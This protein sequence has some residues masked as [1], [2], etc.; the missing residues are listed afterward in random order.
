MPVGEAYD[1]N[2]RVG[3]ICI[4]NLEEEE[5]EVM[6]SSPMPQNNTV[7]FVLVVSTVRAEL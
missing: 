6:E 1:E 4:E 3:S 7:Y 2:S 5:K